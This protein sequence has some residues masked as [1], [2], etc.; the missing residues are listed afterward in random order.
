MAQMRISMLAAD[1]RT[2]HEKSAILF[3]NYIL[4]FD[5]LC[6]TRPSRTGLKFVGGTEQR[7]AGHD[8]N[9]NALF[10]IIPELVP[11]RWF[12]CVFLSDLEL[13]WGQFFSELII[14]GLIINIPRRGGL[15]DNRFIL[16]VF[17][18]KLISS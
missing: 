18:D 9:I 15:L 2:N 1:L 8:I 17:F 11:K 13:Q 7:F 4:R 3:F 6:K 16:P 5:R 14:T 10:M 12:G